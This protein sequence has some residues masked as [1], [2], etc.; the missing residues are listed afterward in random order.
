MKRSHKIAII[1]IVFLLFLY[2]LSFFGS[3]KTYGYTWLNALEA[4][5]LGINGAI[6]IGVY[7]YVE[8][9]GE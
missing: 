2:A 6:F 3:A 9:L 5:A 1:T 7:L 8:R 4:L